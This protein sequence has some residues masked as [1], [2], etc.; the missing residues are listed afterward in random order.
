MKTKLR[1]QREKRIAEGTAFLVDPQLREILEM[2]QLQLEASRRS[3]S[4]LSQRL[5]EY[6][7]RKSYEIAGLKMPADLLSDRLK[8]AR[9]K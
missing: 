1:Q 5:H 7:I 2:A 4:V 9:K 8:A 3:L 6:G